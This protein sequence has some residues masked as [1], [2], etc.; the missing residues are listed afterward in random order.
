M[1]AKGTGRIASQRFCCAPLGK[2]EVPNC[3]IQKTSQ[4]LQQESIMKAL[5]ITLLFVLAVVFFLI[6]NAMAQVVTPPLNTASPVL[7]PAPAGLRTLTTV[8][9]SVFDRIGSRAYDG[10]NIYEFSGSG[11]MANT[12]FRMGERFAFEAFYYDDTT[13]VAKDEYVDNLKVNLKTSDSRA[14]V[15]LAHED[16]A[17]FGLGIHSFVSKDFVS[18]AYPEELTTQSKTIPSLSIKMGTSFYFGLGIE[19]V[20]ET[21][22]Y[23]VE[24]HW[25]N[26]VFGLAYMTEENDDTMFRFELSYLN[27]PEAEAT[28]K[29]SLAASTH[30]KAV[31]TRLNTELKLKG[32]LLALNIK[33]TKEAVSLTHPVTSAAI[34]EIHIVNAEMGFLIVPKEGIVLGFLFI[35][36]KTT[37]VF[38][39]SQDA[40]LI[41]LAYNFGM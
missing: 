41:T 18:T 27:S 17:V 22:T 31:V 10:E 8:G 36:D 15:V 33:D 14:S 25:I 2:T 23:A 12:N 30:N 19:R 11:Y 40:F 7:M 29:D 3:G 32:L 6:P 24:N 4:H 1:F 5:T 38:S 37:Q 39:D 34:E 9:L 21:S 13:T 16:F 20:K 28:A 26:S 35:S